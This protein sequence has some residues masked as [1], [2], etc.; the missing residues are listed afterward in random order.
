MDFLKFLIEK[1]DIQQIICWVNERT[2]RDK[3]TALHYASF[4]GNL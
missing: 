3:F 1:E 2:K 4:R